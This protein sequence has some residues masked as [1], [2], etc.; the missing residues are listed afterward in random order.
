MTK[1]TYT[2]CVKFEKLLFNNRSGS[3]KFW[4]LC[5]KAGWTRSEIWGRG[6]DHSEAMGYEI[7]LCLRAG[8]GL[9][10]LFQKMF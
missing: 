8:G 2:M 1:K 6:G 5:K 9:G 3:T 10:V 7:P 4:P